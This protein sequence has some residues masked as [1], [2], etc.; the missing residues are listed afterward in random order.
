MPTP[1]EVA[2]PK[3][4]TQPEQEPI[5]PPETVLTSI[6]EIKEQTDTAVIQQTSVV[7]AAPPIV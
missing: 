5:K 7:E 6:H 3:D 1:T 2:P 4:L